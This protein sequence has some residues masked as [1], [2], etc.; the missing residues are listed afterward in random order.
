MVKIRKQVY[1]FL[2]F[3][4]L[5]ITTPAFANIETE[6]N[7]I[8]ESINYKSTKKVTKWSSVDW[9]EYIKHIEKDG[10]A[11]Y[12]LKMTIYGPGMQEVIFHENAEFKVDDKV[13][14]INKVPQQSPNKYEKPSRG[15]AF[16]IFD[17][18]QDLLSAIK[19]SKKQLTITFT[20]NNKKPLITK[21]PDQ[22]RLEMIE[23]ASL[24][25]EDYKQVK[26]RK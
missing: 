14:V 8:D 23:T 17:I 26:D 10:Q 24:A 5:F 4:L 1:F 15:M 22:N 21:I 25:R 9:Y 13:F 7:N 2:L 16:A 6:F 19:D 11:S 12:F 18:P 3:F 20:F